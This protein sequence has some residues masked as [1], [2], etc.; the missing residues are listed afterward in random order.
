MAGLSALLHSTGRSLRL[1]P[2]SS[3]S[4]LSSGWLCA[5]NGPGAA[6]ALTGQQCSTPASNPGQIRTKITMDVHRGNVD[7][8][9]RMMFKRMKEEGLEKR[10]QECLVHV[11][12]AEQ[13][14]LDKKES[15]R[16]FMKRDYKK[17]MTWVMR[18]KNRCVLVILSDD[19]NPRFSEFLL[20]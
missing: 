16:R 20:F 4:A 3:S 5:V 8:A 1:L 2:Y 7:Q 13:R 11:T 12:P 6:A 14:K 15:A 17:L 19:A 9:L 18:R 10:Q